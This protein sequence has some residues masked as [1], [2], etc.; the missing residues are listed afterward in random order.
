MARYRVVTQD[1]KA[2]FHFRWTRGVGGPQKR[3]LELL[4]KKGRKP[5]GLVLEV[6]ATWDPKRPGWRPY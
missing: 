3:A 1:R 6:L 5:D 2:L 4:H